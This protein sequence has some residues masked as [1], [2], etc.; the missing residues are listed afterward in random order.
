M[1]SVRPRPPWLTKR[2]WR[3]K[4]LLRRGPRLVVDSRKPMSKAALSHLRRAVRF[5]LYAIGGVFAL[6]AVALGGALFVLAHLESAAVK[7]RIVA[8]AA[9][10]G[11]ALDYEDASVGLRSLHLTKVRVAQPT[12]D[13]RLEPLL[14]VEKIDLSYSALGAIFGGR[15]KLKSGAIEGVRAVIFADDNGETSITRLLARMPKSAP[16]KK[17]QDEPLSKTLAQLSS[18]AA[19]VQQFKLGSVSASLIE[20]RSGAVV[21]ETDLSG[22]EV[23]ASEPQGLLDVRIGS[24]AAGALVTVTEGAK[25][26][27]ALLDFDAELIWSARGKPPHGAFEM[28]VK[29]RHQDLVAMPPQSPDL[30]TL[31]ALHAG[32][33]PEP[34]EGR[35][36]IVIEKLELLD[37]AGTGHLDADLFDDGKGGVKP[38]IHEVVLD[39]VLER[40]RPF[41]PL[42]NGT[43][44]ALS[45]S[46]NV[47]IFGIDLSQGLRIAPDGGAEIKAEIPRLLWKQ[48]AQS[49]E[50]TR[51][52]L[53]LQAKPSAGGVALELEMP[54][55][56]CHLQSGRQGFL[57]SKANLKGQANATFAYRATGGVTAR[58]G[59]L[60]VVGAQT[61]DAEETELRLSLKDADLAAEGPLKISGSVNSELDF[62]HLLAKANGMVVE[63]K[64][65]RL[66]APMR[67]G[68][69]AAS[70]SGE[71]HFESDRLGV[72]KAGRPLLVPTNLS[73]DLTLARFKYDARDAQ[74]STADV[75]LAMA[76]GAVQVNLHADKR[77]RELEYEMT[78]KTSSLS[79]AKPF[80]NA[81]NEDGTE[82]IPWSQIGLTFASKGRVANLGGGNAQRISQET[83][84]GISRGAL[85]REGIDVAFAQLSATMKSHG[86]PL[87]HEA[88]LSLQMSGLVL[89]KKARA[90]DE[91]LA[92]HAVIDRPASNAQ[93]HFEAKG[94]AAPE[95]KMDFS[96]GF[97]S[98]AGRVSYLV[99]GELHRLDLV[100]LFL[101]AAF[102]E[103]TDL[104]W[105][106]LGLALSGKG[107]V[108]GVVTEMHD[109]KPKL[110]V[111]PLKTM[112]G[113]QTFD[114]KIA[115]LD[116]S[117]DHDQAVVL[118][119]AA[120]HLDARED[121]AAKHIE[122]T[123]S[124]PAGELDVAGVQAKF[125]A[126]Q[127]AV[128]IDL[129]RE[130]LRAGLSMKFGSLQQNSL[131][132]YP[133]GDASFDALV[134]SGA[135]GTLHLEH[136]TLDNVAGGTTLYASG[137]IEA[138][139]QFTDGAPKLRPINP[140][141]DV[142][143]R[144]LKLTGELLQRLETIPL[145]MGFT[146]RGTMR[147]PFSAE[148][149][150]FRYFRVGTGLEFKD[151]DIDLPARKISLGKLN[152][153]IP[154]R[155]NFR[156]DEAGTIPLGGARPGVYSR[157]RFVDYQPFLSSEDF[158]SC[159]T[160]TFGRATVGPLAA[161][162]RIDRNVI[163]LDQLELSAF[164]GKITGQFLVDLDLANRQLTDVQFRG[165]VTGLAPGKGEN[166]SHEVVDANA[167]LRLNP[168]KLELE[169]RIDLIRIGRDD[170]RA[171]LDAWDPSH[172]DEQ[173]NR[174]RQALLA[175]YPK[176]VRIGFH[177]G[178][179]EVRMEMGGLAGL[180]KLDPIQLSTG[181]ILQK[182]VAPYL[183]L[184]KP[185]PA[186]AKA[187]AHRAQGTP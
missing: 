40:F 31:L 167:A 42:S 121:D 87:V 139:L 145:E 98:K 49:A 41:I 144:D 67:V 53:S 58:I 107:E 2:T 96:L 185:K 105:K 66:R 54:I 177:Q 169:G 60:K 156:L 28:G 161:N 33:T 184:S 44:S 154:V 22:L 114:L 50:V 179:T 57:L 187:P 183:K 65:V 108:T 91:T 12:P 159:E 136:L 160:L 59:S 74:R 112:R 7:Q 23:T 32:V 75:K 11:I 26:R 181:P 175:G 116:Y 135:D 18:L 118:S 143:Q 158:I 182:Y 76:V 56:L 104:E 129:G 34:G 68:N 16:K 123:A 3:G 128:K 124:A 25:K 61:I 99:D 126:L 20:R 151:A 43:I 8:A 127:S 46:M 71:V 146:G 150:D 63:G 45:G 79:I 155:L 152:A 170:L 70:G 77:A 131:P 64:G 148:S 37:D 117:N 78:A 138:M 125:E 15:V 164:G 10:S 119:A 113:A 24:P 5:G 62:G 176:D 137:I 39:L 86:T 88:D 141:G 27:E 69:D 19:E 6:L 171:M 163:A 132:A 110:A 73:A 92:L 173:A 83:S 149:N 174:T 95:G 165:N 142:E 89:Q 102:T 166:R 80:S 82:P 85:H 186:A 130:S 13:E 140:G 115:G 147:V 93:L 1:S 120:M 14:A 47:R 72:K 9:G 157:E 29:L 51:A 134:T 101:P 38:S 55:E 178:F 81:R 30:K 52:K 48:G 122:F 21:K 84:L 36:R 94:E 109:F 17:D 90:G 97:D 172:S 180:S 4:G 35:T 111:N 100:P 153:K 162:L 106:T 168:K 103:H 133:V